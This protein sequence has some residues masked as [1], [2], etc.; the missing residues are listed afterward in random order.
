M[1]IPAVANLD[2]DL[3]G[4]LRRAATDAADDGVEF[5]V[6]GGWRSPEYQEQLFHEA[7][8]KY[9]SEWKLPDGWPPPTRL[10]TCRGTRSNEEL[11]VLGGAVPTAERADDSA[12]GHVQGREQ[13][14]DPI[15]GVV[16]GALLRHAGHYWQHA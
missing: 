11:P 1:T 13:A 8:S 6:N 16:M 4:A 5:F 15:A 9:G 3:L 14:G 10:H 7:V 12:C 2:P